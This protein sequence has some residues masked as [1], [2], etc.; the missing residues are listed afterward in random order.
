MYDGSY[1]AVTGDVIMVT[2]NYRLGVFGFYTSGDSA[3]RG[4]YGIWDQILADSE[5]DPFLFLMFGNK[6]VRT[7]LHP[8]FLPIFHISLVFQTLIFLLEV[9]QMEFSGRLPR[10][11]QYDISNGHYIDIDVNITT[12]NHL[13]DDRVKFWLTDV[14]SIHHCIDTRSNGSGYITLQTRLGEI[15]GIVRDVQNNDVF[16][17]RKIP[18]AKPPI[19][20]LRFAISM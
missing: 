15:K 9:L 2:I 7:L 6:T 11:N 16:E 1:L 19:G 8:K 17:F 13:Y 4:N 14:P 20:K 3:A 5:V 12:G 10:W 18:F